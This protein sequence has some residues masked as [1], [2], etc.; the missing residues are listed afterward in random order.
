VLKHARG[1]FRGFAV[2][3]AVL[4]AMIVVVAGCSAFT[5]D[6]EPQE[7]DPWA[8]A[9]VENPQITTQTSGDRTTVSVHAETTL[10]LPEATNQD[11]FAGRAAK[12]LWRTHLG[13]VDTLKVITLER[14]HP[15]S[16]RDRTWERAELERE[17]GDRLAGL[18]AG[19][20]A[21]LRQHLP[22]GNGPY[23]GTSADGLPQAIMVMQQIV[24]ET[25][26]ARLDTEPRLDEPEP[27]EC[28]GGI[29]DEPTGKFDAYAPTDL[30]VPE[31]TTPSQVVV[32]AAA[33]WADMGLEVDRSGLF[34]G[35][36]DRIRGDLPD[37]GH[38]ILE[39]SPADTTILHLAYRTEC[40]HP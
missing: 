10:P 11:G 1:R 5:A 29:A 31:G 35:T 2:L 27:E 28:Y 3:A 32:A 6:R 18:D 4:V 20:Q 12:I 8:S 13:R 21:A 30:T 37:V 23:A 33:Q 34:T 14:G 25:A 24:Q 16:R 38:I 15:E 40:F 39:D 17:F 36:E 9:G 19:D 26:R 22:A 7:R